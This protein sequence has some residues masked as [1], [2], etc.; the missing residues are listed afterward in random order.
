M[1][2]VVHTVGHSTRTAGELVALL[3]EHSLRLLVDVRRFPGSRRNPHF[4][5]AA[6]A[7]WLPEAGVRYVHETD[8]GGMREARRGSP[9]TAWREE[10][11]R[12]YAE[13]MD[14]PAFQA[15]LGR[16]VEEA[17]RQPTVVMCAE[18]APTSCHRQLLSDAL[19]VRGHRVVHVLGPGATREHALH[20]A[21]RVLGT[22][23]VYDRAGGQAGLFEG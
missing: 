3:R 15:A 19:V 18:A 21:A 12:A 8:L 20:V 23:I 14:T 2:V 11:F 6:L 10:G 9:H 17:R 13:H 7:G 5:S 4:A 22:R 1:A 16:V